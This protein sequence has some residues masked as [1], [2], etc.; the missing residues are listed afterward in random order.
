[1][2]KTQYYVGASL[3]GYI[4]D[5]QNQIGWLTAFQNTPGLELHYKAFLRDVGALVMGARTYD[6]L[7]E[8][9]GPYPYG[10]LP[11]FV[12]SHRELAPIP[13]AQLRFVRDD[14][15]QVYPDIV[16]AS[17]GKNIWLIGGGDL[18]GQFQEAGLVDELWL[19]LIPVVL[20]AGAP[21]FGTAG[22]PALQLRELTRFDS[23][24]A[25]RYDVARSSVHHASNA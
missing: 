24:V 23:I 8:E 12:F 10:E 16:A 2:T 21:L 18:V 25:L 20:G 9:A 5:A 11:A 17:G 19:S 4:A 3:D 22:V 13:G 6:F 1:M 14:V 15:A 7:L